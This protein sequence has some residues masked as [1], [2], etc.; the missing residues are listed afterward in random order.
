M[1]VEEENESPLLSLQ[2]V[3]EELGVPLQRVK[4]AVAS[5]NDRRAAQSSA[6]GGARRRLYGP[7]AV[8]AIRRQL[9]KAESRKRLAAHEG[10][11]HWQRLARL[12]LCA[13][14]AGRLAGELKAVYGELR[15]YPPTTSTALGT[16]P[17]PQLA[18][19]HP[20]PVL[21]SPLRSAVWQASW[22]EAGI[23]ARALSVGEALRK[24]GLEIVRTWKA[25]ESTPQ[26][27]PE[28]GRVLA[29]V[30]HRPGL[31]PKSETEP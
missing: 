6:G 17:D 9:A 21:L 30:I 1:K 12:R 2:Q 28:L 27:D 13:V 20:I 8:A 25:M 4:T 29:A 22:P 18:L 14:Q 7:E 19:V 15:R 3:A 26:G 31:A 24:L 23:A 5:L 11:A 10:A 16:L